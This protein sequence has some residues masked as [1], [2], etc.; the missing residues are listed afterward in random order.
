M[1]STRPYGSNDKEEWA[2][3]KVSV[4]YPNTEGSK[5]DIDYYVNKHMPMVQ[6]RLGSSCRGLGAE[7]GIAGG[8]PGA[9]PTYSAMGYLLF[10]SVEA[11][12]ASFGPN[13][14]AIMG[15]VPNYT[16]VSPVIQINDVK[17]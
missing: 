16:N 9:P 8:E 15:D 12:Q 14:E 2:M 13:A 1:P 17:L 6:S 5:F 7:Q 4:L 11:F 10:D 3:I